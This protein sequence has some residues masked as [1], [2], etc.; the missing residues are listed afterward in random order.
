VLVLPLPAKGLT[1]YAKTRKVPGRITRS[2]QE[3][4]VNDE[5]LSRRTDPP[6][7]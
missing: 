2:E 6:Q 5:L 1:G 3:I 4:T 7:H